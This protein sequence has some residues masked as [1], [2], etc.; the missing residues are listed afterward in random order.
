M[1]KKL[2]KIYTVLITNGESVRY[3]GVLPEN[4]IV[5]YSFTNLEAATNFI[6]KHA[7]IRSDFLEFSRNQMLARAIKETKGSSFIR[8][9]YEIVENYLFFEEN[10]FK[11]ENNKDI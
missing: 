11:N 10:H 9:E 6:K 2:E 1:S 4:D 3:L 7:S 5:A 8:C